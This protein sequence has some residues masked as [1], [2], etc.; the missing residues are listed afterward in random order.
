MDKKIQVYTSPEIL[1]ELEKVLK[2]DFSEES[3]LI[4]RQISL[5]LEYAILVRPILEPDI[6]KADPDD[7][8]IIACA[9]A[10]KVDYIVSGDPHLYLLKEVFGIEILKP[11]DFL[12]MFL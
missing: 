4:Q 12:D 1:V 10:A 7:N 8:K 11:K 2:R 3:V 6:V 9:L 5:I